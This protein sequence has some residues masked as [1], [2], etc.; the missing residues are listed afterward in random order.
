MLSVV[1]PCYNE[2]DRL[3][4]TVEAIK[5]Y[6]GARGVDYEMILADDGSADGTGRVIDAAIKDAPNVRA[7]RLVANRG[8]GRALAEGVAVSRGDRVL[9]TDADLS[10]P[11]EELP[12][13]EAKLDAGAGVAIAS[14]SI[15]G[16]QVV[17]SQPVYRVLMGKTFNLMVQALLLPGLWDTQ[18]GFKLFKGDLA[19]SVFA[20]LRT[21]G[22][23]YDPEALFLA[24]KRGARIAEVPVVWRHSAPTKVAAIRH[25]LDMFKDLVGVRFRRYAPS[26]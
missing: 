3:P 6:L 14:R 8:K 11:I 13:L 16:S 10:T 26:R 20:D 1:I 9:L 19:R 18:C 21:D 15:K 12:K 4:A 22:F 5:R 25:S 24:K 23:G 17:V 2:Q 7:V